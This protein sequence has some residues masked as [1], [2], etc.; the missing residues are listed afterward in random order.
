MSLIS[1]QVYEELLSQPGS[2]PN[3]LDRE[4]Q[5]PVLD[6]SAGSGTAISNWQLQRGSGD[7]L[8]TD[9]RQRWHQPIP[10]LSRCIGK[11][12]SYA[13]DAAELIAALKGAFLCK[14]PSAGQL[15]EAVV[16]TPGDQE[17]ANARALEAADRFILNW[18][19]D[20]VLVKNGEHTYVYLMVS[21]PFSHVYSCRALVYSACVCSWQALVRLLKSRVQ[22]FSTLGV[23]LRHDLVSQSGAGSNLA[24]AARS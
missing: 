8:R 6:H 7:N 20:D 17:A 13:A 24:G 16:G 4:G 12:Q 9:E 15:P 19:G 18:M 1:F 10:V 23:A 2:N 21:S 22:R 5:S 14:S 11:R 3:L